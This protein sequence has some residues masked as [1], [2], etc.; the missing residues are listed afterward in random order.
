LRSKKLGSAAHCAPA[1]SIGLRQPF[2]PEIL[3]IRTQFLSVGL[4][5]AV[6]S[7]YES[8]GQ[9]GTKLKSVR[10][11]KVTG[12]AK[13]L[14][15]F[16]ALQTTQEFSNSQVFLFHHLSAYITHGISVGEG[17]CLV[18]ELQENPR[19]HGRLLHGRK[20]PDVKIAKV[21]QFP[22][23]MLLQSIG[24]IL[25]QKPAKRTTGFMKDRENRLID[26][27]LLMSSHE[28]ASAI[29]TPAQ[30]ATRPRN[31]LASA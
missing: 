14:R 3:E 7:R 9:T 5:H 13:P 31:K 28:I 15:N 20:T 23:C 8:R 1:N 17:R 21:M 2:V 16:G 24:L 12:A 18:D 10:D 30:M 29:I 11:A 22:F 27:M 4:H 26:D 25:L 19:R 6:D